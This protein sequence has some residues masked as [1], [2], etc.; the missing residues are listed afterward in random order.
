VKA[1]SRKKRA[2]LRTFRR[3]RRE[4]MVRARH[5]RL[6]DDHLAE[7]R[8]MVREWTEKLGKGATQ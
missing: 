5:I 2:A 4:E 1:S 6:L 7:M 8:S 3:I